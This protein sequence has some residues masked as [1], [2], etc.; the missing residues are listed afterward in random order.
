MKSQQQQ[1]HKRRA[2]C[3]HFPL[4]FSFLHN[5]ISAKTRNRNRNREARMFKG[6]LNKNHLED[7]FRFA[8]FLMKKSL[9]AKK[10]EQQQVKTKTM[11]KRKMKIIKIKKNNPKRYFSTISFVLFWFFVRIL[12]SFF[13]RDEYRRY[14]N[15]I[16]CGNSPVY[17]HSIQ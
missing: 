5:I 7:S 11:R 14:I 15:L 10:S 16:I 3:L 4:S 17:K 9:H 1:Q 13:F 6:K 8:F 2:E 12:F